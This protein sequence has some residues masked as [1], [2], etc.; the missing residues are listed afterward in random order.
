VFTARYAL[1]PYIKQIRF[2]FK[3]SMSYTGRID[4]W[5]SRRVTPIFVGRNFL[6]PPTICVSV[7]DYLTE[8]RN[9]RFPNTNTQTS[10]NTVSLSTLQ[11]TENVEH[12]AFSS[13][14]SF[15]I[16]SRIS[17]QNN[18]RNFKVTVSLYTVLLLE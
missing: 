11:C 15:R 3:G 4:S 17:E 5:S 13:A 12:F 8:I 7:V 18:R 2:V 1:S 6:K 14:K 16:N 9:G 10:C